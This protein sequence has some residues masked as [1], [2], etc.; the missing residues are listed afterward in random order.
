MLWREAVEASEDA[1]FGIDAAGLVVTWTTGAARMFGCPA[2]QM[3]GQPSTLLI[4]ADHLEA[5]LV[6]EMPSDERAG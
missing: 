4:P 1:V 6:A 5:D 3:I 2:A